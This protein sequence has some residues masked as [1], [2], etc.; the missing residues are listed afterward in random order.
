MTVKIGIVTISDR[1]SRGEYEDKSGPALEAWLNEVISSEWLPEKR[2]I[3]DGIASVEACL[4]D[5]CDNVQ[6]DLILTTGGTGPSPRDLTP[7]AM[8]LVMEK[9]LLGFGELM[10]KVS[11]ETGSDASFLAARNLYLSE[12]FAVC[13]PF[14][15]YTLD[16]LSVFMTR[17]L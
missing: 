9:E 8:A 5:L 12:G 11:L 10:R 13:P 16:P 2:V 15:S 14:G 7:E 17:T 4:K 1:A 6:V 3:E